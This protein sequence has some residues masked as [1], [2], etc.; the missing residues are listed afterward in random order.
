M[1][2]NNKRIISYEDTDIEEVINIYGIDF[3]MNHIDIDRIR[4]VNKT[5]KKAIE[6][7]IKS[8]LGEDSIEKL[9]NK[10]LEDNAGE[11]LITHELAIVGYLLQAFA[12]GTARKQK[13]AINYTKEVIDTYTPNANRAQRRAQYKQNRY[14]KGR[15][16]K[17]NKRY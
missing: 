16:G 10:R 11:L 9:N 8:V 13:E 15:Y 14:N 3:K 7:I 1:I 5:D 2:D 17:Y 6:E 4:R 12:E